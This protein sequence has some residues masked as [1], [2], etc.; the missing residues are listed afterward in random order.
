MLEKLMG[1]FH[2][3]VLIGGMPEKIAD[4]IQHKDL[5]KLGPVYQAFAS[6]LFR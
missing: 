4:Y 1:L 3:Y 2:T 5:R 6:V